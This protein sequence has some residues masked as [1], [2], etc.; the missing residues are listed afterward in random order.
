[1]RKDLC[2]YKPIIDAGAFTNSSAAWVC[3]ARWLQNCTKYHAS[4][5]RTDQPPY[6]SQ[7]PTRLLDVG[8]HGSGDY[9]IKLIE[10]HDV[11]PEGPYVTL[12]HCWGKGHITSLTKANIKQFL[13]RV[14]ALPKTYRDA[15]TVARKL[16]VRYLWIDSL[17][18][19]Q[20]DE[21]DWRTESLLMNQVYKNAPFNIAATAASDSRMGLFYSRPH[22]VPCYQVQLGGEEVRF[23]DTSQ[24]IAEVVNAP[25]LQVR[26]PQIFPTYSS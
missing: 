8:V 19:I 15:I 23:V 2:Q 10:T 7:Y 3:I 12:S 4:C 13:L 16:Q 11:V 14:P 20:D 25:L 9:D 26:D 1:M 18:I 6:A 5:G 21:D 24:F 22:L 17:C